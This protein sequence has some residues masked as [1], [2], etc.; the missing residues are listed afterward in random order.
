MANPQVKHS[1]ATLLSRSGGDRTKITHLAD[2]LDK[3]S[4]ML[5]FGVGSCWLV[6]WIHKECFVCHSIG[7]YRFSGLWVHA[8]MQ[9]LYKLL[10]PS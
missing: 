8:F 3:V 9:D 10:A 1:F 4:G 2:L 6:R 5:V 7:T